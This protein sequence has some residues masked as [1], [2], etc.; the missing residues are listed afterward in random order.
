MP[1]TAQI[2]LLRTHVSYDGNEGSI[3]FVVLVE[4]VEFLR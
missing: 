3:E 1:A 2:M 4:N